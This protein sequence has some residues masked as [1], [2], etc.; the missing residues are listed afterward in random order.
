MNQKERKELQEFA[1]HV[2]ARCW[3]DE[4]TESLEMDSVLVEAFSKRLFKMMEVITLVS[5]A[6][7]SN[8]PVMEVDNLIMQWKDGRL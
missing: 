1:R 4:E 3:C 8:P 6:H 2:A 7:W 5:E